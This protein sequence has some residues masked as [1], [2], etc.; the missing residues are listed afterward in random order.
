MPDMSIGSST[1]TQTCLPEDPPPGSGSSIAQNWDQT[2]YEVADVMDAT[3]SFVLGS[4]SARD[5]IDQFVQFADQFRD[6]VVDTHRGMQDSYQEAITA[7]P[8][9]IHY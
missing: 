6:S 4:G 2:M 1:S 7:D 5:V 8:T 3:R 9:L